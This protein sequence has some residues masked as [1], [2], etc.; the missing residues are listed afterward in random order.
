MILVDLKLCE[1]LTLLVSDELLSKLETQL[2]DQQSTSDAS[3]LSDELQ[4]LR[5]DLKLMIDEN[6]NRDVAQPAPPPPVPENQGSPELE[7][8]FS[9][10]C[11]LSGIDVHEVEYTDT[12]A[13][14]NCAQAGKYGGKYYY[15]FYGSKSF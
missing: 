3:G 9:L 15:V 4:S 11:S 5:K 12:E 10:A 14:Y 13:I 2:K 8:A 6:V 1:S 7:H